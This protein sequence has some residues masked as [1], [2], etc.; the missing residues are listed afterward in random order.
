MADLMYYRTNL[1][2]FGTLYY[3]IILTL[4]SSIICC[5]F[6]GDTYLSFGIS[7]S[8]LASSKLFCE[9]FFET[10]SLSE[11]FLPIKSPV[12]FAVFLNCSF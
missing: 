7:S 8:V 3:I 6:S 10:L 11:I 4:N 5:L 1:L 2:F 9:N 12:A